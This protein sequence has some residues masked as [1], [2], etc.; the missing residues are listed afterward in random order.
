MTSALENAG[1]SRIAALGQREKDSRV[2]LERAVDEDRDS[3]I[4][5]IAG[6]TDE[7]RP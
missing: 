5:Y 6:R 3:K 4:I 7:D 1:L 2:I